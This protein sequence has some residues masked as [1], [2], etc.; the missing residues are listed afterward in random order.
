MQSFE[1]P[2]K[3]P[4]VTYGRRARAHPA[5]ASGTDESKRRKVESSD[6]TEMED[7]PTQVGRVAAPLDPAG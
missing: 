6:D 7:A 2:K 4:A 1:L 5:K 3:R